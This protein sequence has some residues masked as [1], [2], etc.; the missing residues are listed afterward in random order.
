MAYASLSDFFEILL[1]FLLIYFALK[2]FFRFLGP[3]LMRYAL[4]KMGQ[5]AEEQFKKSHQNYTQHTPDEPAKTTINKQTQTNS[6]TKK[7]MGEYID[8]EEID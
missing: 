3:I 6:S 8:Y 5:K 4:R 1:T 2:L 7:D